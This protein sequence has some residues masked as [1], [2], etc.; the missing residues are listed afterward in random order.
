MAVLCPECFAM[1]QADQDPDPSQ[2]VTEVDARGTTTPGQGGGDNAPPV[3][4]QNFETRVSFAV[5]NSSRAGLPAWVWAIP[6]WIAALMS[7]GWVT[8][9]P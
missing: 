5:I 9:S 6:R 3:R 8:R 7:P 4:P 2:E 1:Q